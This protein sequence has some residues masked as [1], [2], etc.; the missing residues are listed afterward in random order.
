MTH[1]NI[2]DIVLELKLY[3]SCCVKKT[4]QTCTNTIFNGV[5]QK[6]LLKMMVCFQKFI[7]SQVQTN[8][9][10]MPLGNFLDILLEIGL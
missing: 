8:E 9:T 10:N 6:I 3:V 7:H 1:G 2:K 4:P 5:S